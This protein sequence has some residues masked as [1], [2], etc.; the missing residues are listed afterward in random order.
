MNVPLKDLAK[1]VDEFATEIKNN[2]WLSDYDDEYYRQKSEN[3]IGDIIENG[4]DMTSINR[5][6]FREQPNKKSYGELCDAFEFIQISY[7]SSTLYWSLS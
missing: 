3:I 6:P 4:L 2:A 7:T 1:Y 5:W